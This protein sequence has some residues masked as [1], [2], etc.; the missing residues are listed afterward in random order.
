MRICSLNFEFHYWLCARYH[1]EADA[2]KIHA[3]VACLDAEALA[4]VQ[5]LF[6]QNRYHEEI[7]QLLL[8]TYIAPLDERL[9]DILNLHSIRDIKLSKF[10]SQARSMISTTDMSDSVL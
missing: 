1:I 2:D 5:P 9:S 3:L 6:S 4:V 10:I 7:R 8:E